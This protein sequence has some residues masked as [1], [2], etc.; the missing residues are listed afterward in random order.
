VSAP[1]GNKR[2]LQEMTTHSTMTTALTELANR[3]VELRVERVVMRRQVADTGSTAEA[4]PNWTH[5]PFCPGA[6][7][8]DTLRDNASCDKSQPQP[9]CSNAFSAKC[10]IRSAADRLRLRAAKST[11]RYPHLRSG[12][13][14]SPERAAWANP[15]PAVLKTAGQSGLR[16]VSHSCRYGVL[17]GTLASCWHPSTRT[18]TSGSEIDRRAWSM[19][20]GSSYQLSTCSA[21]RCRLVHAIT[22]DRLLSCDALVRP[23]QSPC[24]AAQRRLPSR[25]VRTTGHHGPIDPCR[26]RLISVRPGTPPCTCILRG[27]RIQR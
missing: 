11:T 22:W 21:H 5:S 9:L 15:T 16:A 3:L 17:L 26:Q 23:H 20:A 25:G 4:F 8:R 14:I 10:S 1:A 27:P 18:G 24:R 2:R 12:L 7:T 6:A 19:L 13:K